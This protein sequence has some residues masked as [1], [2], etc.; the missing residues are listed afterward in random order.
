MNPAPP[1]PAWANQL[2]ELF[3]S[4]STV[5]F[6]LH[7][8]TQDLV[9]NGDGF[10]PLPDFLAQQIF[11]RWDL[12]LYYDLARGLRAFAGSDAAR[13]KEMVLLANRKVGDLA[14]ARRDPAMAFALLDRF[15]QNNIMAADA[16]RISAAVVIDH[17]GFLLPA[18]EP[19]RLSVPAATQVVTLLNW[20]ASPHLKR[21]NMAFLV[22]DEK[23][24]A[25]NERL[26]ASP[27]T[28]AIEIPLPDEATRA[29]FAPELAAQ[30]AGLTLLDLRALKESK[31]PLEPKRLRE[32][33][34][35]LIER[36][37]QGLLE[38]IEPRWNFSN[39]IGHP[40]IQ[41]RL[42]DDATLLRQGNL[43]ALP[44]G[45]LV[46]GP[47]GTG[48]SFLAQCLAGE[49]GIPC[50]TLRNFRSK[51]VGETEGNLERLLNLLR[52][53]GPVIVVVDE[54]DAALGDRDQE[55]DSGTGSRVFSMI[56][57]QMG[58]TRYRGKI[59]WMLLTA[60]PDLLPID[61]KRQGRAE[62]HIPLFYPADAAQVRAMFLAMA[63]KAHTPLAEEDIPPIPHLGQLS[64]ADVEGIVGRA[65][66]QALLA[67]AAGI[68][69]EALAA[70]VAEFLP[71]TQS[72]EKEMQEIAAILECTDRQFLPP[73]ILE[74][75]NAYGGREKLQERYTQLRRMIELA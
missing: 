50:V 57:T 75:M 35:M 4:G 20:A 18:G 14:T 44:M 38:F 36:Q 54:A 24:S 3:Y 34:K 47:V 5:L 1:P 16:D 45:Y 19:G 66:R 13:L 28:A 70:A 26:T 73:E 21:L 48:K 53:L 25:L 6:A 23:L 67:G 64:G 10:S 69:R 31:E 7:G 37:S 15:V 56:A 60:R 51:Y 65:A 33:K 49:I 71:S 74:K 39:W 42:R 27:H 72:L 58:D 55:G 29:R 9:P 8:N 30:T 46:C 41:Q 43:N 62:V 68:T 22:I 32:L 2:T 17:A 61:L 40:P 12:V 52:A 59:L 63:R 11:G